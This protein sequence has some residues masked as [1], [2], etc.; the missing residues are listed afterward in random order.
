[1]T[2]VWQLDALNPL[3]Y[4]DGGSGSMIFQV[5]LATVLTAGYVL[6]SQWSYFIS[7][8]RKSLKKVRVER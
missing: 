1:M 2:L 7:L 8:F 6:R 3:A 4:I 5:I